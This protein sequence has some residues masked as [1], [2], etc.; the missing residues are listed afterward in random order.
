M[1][2]EAG[3]GPFVLI[4][5]TSALLTDDSDN[6]PVFSPRIWPWDKPLP[7]GWDVVTLLTPYQ[8]KPEPDPEPEAIPAVEPDMATLAAQAECKDMAFKLLCGLEDMTASSIYMGVRESAELARQLYD[9]L[10]DGSGE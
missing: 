10:P 6:W 1:T 4:Y 2:N 3:A 9:K 5:L 7:D 8:T